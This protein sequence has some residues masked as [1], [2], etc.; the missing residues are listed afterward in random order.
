[1]DKLWLTFVVFVTLTLAY[2]EIYFLEPNYAPTQDSPSKETVYGN[3]LIE[4]NVS[5]DWS[6]YD[7]GWCAVKCYYYDSSS[8]QLGNEIASCDSSGEWRTCNCTWD[9]SSLQ[10]GDYRI[11]VVLESGF[12]LCSGSNS[13]WVRVSS[14]A[15]IRIMSPSYAP[16]ETSQ[17]D[18]VKEDVLVVANVTLEDWENANVT[19]WYEDPSEA[20]YY[21]GEANCSG[22]GTSRICNFTWHTLEYTPEGDAADVLEDGNYKVIVRVLGS[23]NY[24]Y[25]TLDNPPVVKTFTEPSRDW[26]STNTIDVTIEELSNTGGFI[27]MTL[28]CDSDGVIENYTNQESASWK[29]E[30]SG[31]GIYLI[32]VTTFDSSGNFANFTKRV[33]VDFTPPVSSIYGTFN[34]WINESDIRVLASDNLAEPNIMYLVINSTETCPDPS[35]TPYLAGG[36]EVN[37]TFSS[38]GRYRICYFSEDP[39][40]NRENLKVSDDVL[41]DFEAPVVIITSS[42]EQGKWCSY[43]DVNISFVD[44]LSGI[45]RRF[46]SITQ[47]GCTSAEYQEASGNVSFRL[48]SDGI[49]TICARAFDMAGNKNSTELGPIKI[50]VNS[51]VLYVGLENNSWFNSSNITIPF[52]F[53]DISLVNASFLLFNESWQNISFFNESGSYELNFSLT[54]GC[55]WIKLNASDALN[56]TSSLLYR[57]C[58]DTIVP[59]LNFSIL[60]NKVMGI[61]TS[62]VLHVSFNAS[63]ENFVEFKIMLNSQVLNSSLSKNGSLSFEVPQGNL[64]ICFSACD[65]VNCNVTCVNISVD[66]EPPR[67]EIES[68]DFDSITSTS[69]LVKVSF[70][71]TDDFFSKVNCRVW[72]D[73][74][75]IF[76]GELSRRYEVSDSFG[77]GKH[78]L[79]ICCVDALNHSSCREKEFTINQEVTSIFIPLEKEVLEKVSYRGGFSR[80]SALVLPRTS[81]FNYS[82][83]LVKDCYEFPLVFRI[84]KNG[85]AVENAYL[86]IF[87]EKR[88]KIYSGRSSKNGE[89]EVV[90]EKPGLYFV[91]SVKHGEGAFKGWFIVRSCVECYKNEDCAFDEICKAYRCEKIK[92]TCGKIVNHTCMAYECCSNKDC[93]EGRICRNHRCIRIEEKREETN[94]IEPAKVEKEVSGKNA[95]LPFNRSAFVPMR[96]IFEFFI[97]FLKNLFRA[98]LRI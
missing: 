41:I 3:V 53:S 56:R 36:N 1:M 82:V 65:Y 73:S 44:S 68:P 52:S 47:N 19:C 54:D 58:I 23:E 66:Y 11:E 12:G 64:T 86:V 38:G 88:R 87:D 50:D 40:G 33:G 70:T 75:L 61:Y 89:I 76:S 95:I 14:G 16:L 7:S 31:E 45:H 37:V 18:T 6:S 24:T 78:L 20:V 42:C 57:F 8:T 15:S 67:I 17:K 30:Y 92:C 9:T 32:T 10:E 90:V 55:Y 97:E 84:T 80:A 60:E 63:D 72:V 25:V 43:A 29:C 46:Y 69:S 77:F 83:E 4:T 34:E 98:I 96:G 27:N 21:L 74:N 59:K 22:S 79:K 85:K 35:L 51:P 49:Y 26:Y 62:R 71:A 39:A 28:D 94:A 13:T 93:G 81:Y 91:Y 5:T 2:S 48:N